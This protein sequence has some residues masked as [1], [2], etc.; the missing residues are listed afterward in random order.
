MS[1]LALSLTLSAGQK[2][3][4]LPNDL[5][6]CDHCHSLRR[7]SSL[8]GMVEQDR[9]CH[10]AAAQPAL[11]RACTITLRGNCEELLGLGVLPLEKAR[12]HV[13]HFCEGT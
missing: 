12:Q 10:A 1:V 2:K 9:E 5:A 4:C 13:L 11:L 6:C 7:P 3:Q 8:R